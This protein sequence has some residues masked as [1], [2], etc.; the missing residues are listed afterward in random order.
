MSELNKFSFEHWENNVRPDLPRHRDAGR[1][2]QRS[3]FEAGKAAG[4]DRVQRLKKASLI[5]AAGVLNQAGYT[6][7][8]AYE[9]IEQFYGFEWSG[10]LQDFVH[11]ESGLTAD[12]ISCL[13]MPEARGKE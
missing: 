9:L 6:C 4:D 10:E 7:V 12:Q 13:P 5:L 8:T 2:I 11:T 3:A 1:S